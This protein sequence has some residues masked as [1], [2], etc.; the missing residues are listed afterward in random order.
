MH[1]SIVNL[2]SILIISLACCSF[3]TAQ[4]LDLSLDQIIARAEAGEVDY[5]ALLGER[6]RIGDY[7]EKDL[8]EALIWLQKACGE[9]SSVAKFGL[10][11]MLLEGKAIAPD[12]ARA[13]ILLSEAIPGLLKSSELGNSLAQLTLADAYHDGHGVPQDYLEAKKWYA[14]AVKQGTPRA[15]NALGVMYINGEGSEPFPETAALWFRRAALQ[16]YPAGMY[17]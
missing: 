14:R 3:S 9:G 17:N 8:A 13:A 12:S 11:V 1:K 15:Q 5:Q 6:Y 7:G 16:D 10:A 4:N 2:S